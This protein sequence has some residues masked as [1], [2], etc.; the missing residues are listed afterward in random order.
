MS[1]KAKMPASLW[2]LTGLVAVSVAAAILSGA[3]L[4]VQSRNLATRQAEA[5]TGGDASAGKVAYV[6]YGCGGCH[7]M[8]G[9]PG[10]QGEVGPP[11]DGIATRAH[12][13]GR[14]PNSPSS[15]RRWLQHPQAIAP[16]SGMP[17]LG[18][19]NRDARD[20]AA[21]LYTAK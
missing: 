2:W 9:A 3:T 21:Y 12:L 15:M 18:V 5:L 13:A 20:L 4:Y 7:A 16:G 19:T 11:L 17:E 10:V 14:L 1:V 6:G 8:T